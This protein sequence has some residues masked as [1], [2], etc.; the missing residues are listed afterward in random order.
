MVASHTGNH[1]TPGHSVKI[2]FTDFAASD[3]FANTGPPK[4][5]SVTQWYITQ[6]EFMPSPTQSPN[7]RYHHPTKELDFHTR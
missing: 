4:E 2:K 3:F 7:Y 5:L 1:W 6:K